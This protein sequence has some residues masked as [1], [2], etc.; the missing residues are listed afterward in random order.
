MAHNKRLGRGWSWALGIPR[1]HSRSFFNILL[2]VFLFLVL[3]FA[4]S[5]LLEPFHF[6]IPAVWAAQAPLSVTWDLCR[7]K[8]YNGCWVLISLWP[9]NCRVRLSG[10]SPYLLQ[11]SQNWTPN[12][13]WTQS[14]RDKLSKEKTASHSYHSFKEDKHFIF[15][16]TWFQREKEW[17]PQLSKVSN[18]ERKMH[19]FCLTWE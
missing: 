5:W 18:E 16:E 13:L 1:R 7:Q 11:N 17:Q 12:N 19:E 4:V 2:F 8:N 10:P 15:L 9:Q 6:P 14:K 3:G